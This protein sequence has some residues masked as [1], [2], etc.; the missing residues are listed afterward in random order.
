MTTAKQNLTA[1][2]HNDWTAYDRDGFE[3][4][5]AVA[6]RYWPGD[7][8]SVDTVS[9]GANEHRI[10]ELT[11]NDDCREIVSLAGGWSLTR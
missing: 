7:A 6:V 1:L 3:Q 10:D 4:Q 8:N 11:I 9:V 5:R 2:N